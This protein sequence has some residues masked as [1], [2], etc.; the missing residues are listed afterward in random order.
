MKSSFEIVMYLLNSIIFI[1]IIWRIYRLYISDGKLEIAINEY[2]SKSGLTVIN[3][4]K[5]NMTEKIKYGVP[6]SVFRVYSYYFGLFSGKIEYV[7]KIELIDK[8]E[9]EY[10]KYVEF[11]I[12]NKAIVNFKE[13]DSYNI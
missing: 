3:I 8:H 11:L 10:T 7:R 1:W 9:N 13:F 5:L 2:Y 6:I 4:S 12:R